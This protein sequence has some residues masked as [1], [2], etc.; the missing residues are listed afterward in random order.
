MFEMCWQKNWQK[1][2]WYVCLQARQ[3]KR[4]KKRMGPRGSRKLGFGWEGGMFQIIVIWVPLISLI[5]VSE[6]LN[7]TF[8]LFPNLGVHLSSLRVLKMLPHWPGPVTVFPDRDWAV[9]CPLDFPLLSEVNGEG[10]PV[11]SSASGQAI[12]PPSVWIGA[13]AFP[14]T[15]FSITGFTFPLFFKRC[16]LNVFWKPWQWA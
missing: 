5:F 4:Q 9:C 8:S 14:V 13:F 15:K 2:E 10:R 3:Q 1:E 12:L 11:Q 16:H 7:L 6:Y